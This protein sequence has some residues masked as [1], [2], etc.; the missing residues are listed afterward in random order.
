MQFVQRDAKTTKDFPHDNLSWFYYVIVFNFYVT[1]MHCLSSKMPPKYTLSYD[2]E[3]LFSGEGHSQ[4]SHP[5]DSSCLRC[6]HCFRSSQ[7]CFLPTPFIVIFWV[8]L[9]VCVLILCDCLLNL[10]TLQLYYFSLS[11][12]IDAHCVKYIFVF[13]FY[14]I[15]FGPI[16]VL[17]LL[18][19]DIIEKYYW[20][21]FE[22]RDIILLSAT[23]SRHCNKYE[24]SSASTG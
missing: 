7:C 9:C 14:S 13:H 17:F 12:V 23:V 1:E 8:C 4:T 11:N 10:M 6:S 19:R 18:N 3:S 2:T 22:Y 16:C 5:A 20:D 15:M 21:G 24:N